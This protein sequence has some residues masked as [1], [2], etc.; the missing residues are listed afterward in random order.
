MNCIII[1][2]DPLSCKVLEKLISKVEDVTLIATY[3]SAVAA[4]PS[5][6]NEEVDLIF[7]DVEMPEMT[8]IEFLHTLEKQ[9]QIIIVSSNEKYALDAFDLNVTDYMLKPPQ[10]ARFYKAVDKVKRQQARSGTP[11]AQNEI[12]FK[13]GSVFVKVTI[14]DILWIEA[15]ENYCNI[16]TLND[17]IV[18]HLNLKGVEKILPTDKFK[19][20]HRSYIINL[21]KIKTVDQTSVTIE[22]TKGDKKVPVSRSYRDKLLEHIK[23]I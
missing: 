1:D 23:I 5:I 12:F 8:G 11:T 21:K 13:S 22:T 4:L 20:V 18:A 3:N 10:F 16:N 17:Q 9:P 19:R 2:D 7:L 15:L 14:D 6:K